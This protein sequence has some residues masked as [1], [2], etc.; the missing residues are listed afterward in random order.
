M[1]TC[2]A[3]CAAG[4]AVAFSVGG[5]N[6]NDEL[7]DDNE[8]DVPEYKGGAD[9]GKRDIYETLGRARPQKIAPA[10]Q[11]ES[12]DSAEFAQQDPAFESRLSFDQSLDQEV[13]Q[14]TEQNITQDM[15]QDVPQEL[16]RELVQ[17]APV[18][19]PPVSPEPRG[20]LSFGL[21]VLRLVLGGLLVVRGAQTLFSFAGDPGIEI[22]ER[23]LAD[24]TASGV[25]AV[26]IPTAEIVAGGLL[27]FG[28]L[29]PLGASLAAVVAGFMGIHHLDAHQGSLWPY[30]L[31]PYVQTWGLMAVMAMMLVFTGPGGISLDRG[32][33]WNRRPLVSAWIFALVAVAGLVALW[34][35]VGGRNPF[36]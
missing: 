5:V 33:G 9:E 34:L 18:E 21:L 26:A 10:K 24:Y 17:E 6:P 11:S 28:L 16:V 31:S 12:V 8:L 35:G 14:E 3:A 30:G 15:T 22:L 7:F 25:L 29:T 13:A 20:T 4:H 23:Q 1:V 36:N 2:R 32:R 27:I 19:E